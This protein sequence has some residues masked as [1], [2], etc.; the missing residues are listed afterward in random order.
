MTRGVGFMGLPP[1]SFWDMTLEEFQHAAEGFAERMEM[2][3]RGHWERARWEASISLSPHLKKGRKLVPTDLIQFPWEKPERA[4]M[5]PEELR[6]SILD[7][8]LGI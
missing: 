4:E 2:E 8:E 5:T 1:A 3:Q 6:E 7:R